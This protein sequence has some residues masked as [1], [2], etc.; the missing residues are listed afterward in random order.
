M[1]GYRTRGT[2]SR[3]SWSGRWWDGRDCVPS[4]RVAM[5]S[6]KV[7][8]GARS[9]RMAGILGG[10]GRPPH[11]SR[12]RELS[13]GEAPK[14]GRPRRARAPSAAVEGRCPP[15]ARRSLPAVRTRKGRP[16]RRGPEHGAAPRALAAHESWTRGS[17]RCALGTFRSRRLQQRLRSGCGSAPPLGLRSAP[18][19]RSSLRLSG[20]SG[21]PPSCAPPPAP[22]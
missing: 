8:C 22:G 9:P 11:P 1:S 15:R 16:R 17:A 19:P 14:V 20:R 6:R 21:S 2:L 4:K 18:D 3:D 12:A 13:A 10:Q 7:F 5:V